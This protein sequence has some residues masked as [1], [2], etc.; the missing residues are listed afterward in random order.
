MFVRGV[1]YESNDK[2]DLNFY[3]K[4]VVL[5]KL[6]CSLTS[7]TK[8]MQWADRSSER[9]DVPIKELGFLLP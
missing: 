5:S 2:Y 1:G 7:T 4:N 3:R 8:L 9:I 6:Y